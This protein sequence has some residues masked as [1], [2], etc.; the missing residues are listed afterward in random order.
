M[1]DVSVPAARDGQ[2]RA[3]AVA[4]L[5]DFVIIG[6]QKAATTLV[7]QWLRQHP[8]A[9]LPKAED[10]YFRD[11]VYGTRDLDSWAQQ[12]AG[13]TER[14]LGLKCPDYLARPEV[15][16]RLHRDLAE[17]D[18]IVCLRDPVARALSAYFWWMRWGLIPIRPA[19]E[20]LWRILDGGYRDLD[21]TVGDVLEWG[22]YHRH[23]T[24]FLGHFPHEK[25]L[26]LFDEDLRRKPADA[27]RQTHEFLGIDPGVAPPIMRAEAN[28][29]V[30]S[31]ERLRFLQRR[32]KHMLRWDPA[33]TY[34]SLVHP[35]F[36]LPRLYTDAVAFADRYVLARRHPN[37]KPRL[38]AELTSALRDYYR[39]DVT[40]L[41]RLVGRDLTS[42]NP[43][44]S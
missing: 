44:T 15:P 30:Y 25:L 22:L 24:R 10:P 16:L 13:R 21:P 34:P 3:T 2:A 9:W 26:V 8:Q 33:R 27:L 29:G 36:P 28:P 14:R 5:P 4:A 11:P 23:L 12:Y 40:A 43:T 42:W 37:A 18:L 19:E 20:G 1:S 7:H 41:E 35:S 17:P 38:S 32:T 6:A 39:A 31:L